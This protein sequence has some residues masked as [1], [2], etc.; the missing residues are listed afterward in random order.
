[1]KLFDI[2]VCSDNQ[3][4]VMVVELSDHGGASVIDIEGSASYCSW[5]SE[6]G[7]PQ[8]GINDTERLYVIG[9]ALDYIPYS[10]L[11]GFNPS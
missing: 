3:A 9:N 2:A 1:M 6:A 5:W 4:I 7:V 10:T 11:E 8:F